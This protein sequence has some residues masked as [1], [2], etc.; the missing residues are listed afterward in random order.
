MNCVLQPAGKVQVGKYIAIFFLL[1][2]SL[3]KKY[4]SAVYMHIAI[5]LFNSADS[6]QDS[7]PV[8]FGRSAA[9]LGWDMA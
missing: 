4:G 8:S 9:I 3:C 7:C 5:C 2:C 6:G 1:E